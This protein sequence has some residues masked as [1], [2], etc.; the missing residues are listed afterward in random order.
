MDKLLLDNVNKII[1]KDYSKNDFNI[2][3][4]LRHEND[5]VM[6][7]SKFIFELLNPVGSH[8]L[9]G[10][11]LKLFVETINSNLD[12]TIPNFEISDFDNAIVY[13]E[14]ENIDVL[15]LF[16]KT[17]YT[18][19]IENKIYAE[20]QDRQLENYYNKM[21]KYYNRDS[22]KMFI[23]YLSLDN[24]LPKKGIGELKH[25]VY[26]ISYPR[27]IDEWLERCC[28]EI[29]Q[30]QNLYE[31]V[32]QYKIL[33]C[34]LSNKECGSNELNEIMELLVKDKDVFESAIAIEQSLPIAKS[35]IMMSFFNNIETEINK[36]GY[37]TIIFDKS[38]VKNYYISKQIPKLNFLIKNFENDIDFS[39]G[40]EIY[41]NLYYY[42]SFC[43]KEEGNYKLIPLENVEKNYSD[44]FDK[45]KKAIVTVNGDIK[46]NTPIALM[47]EYI[48]D[49]GGKIYNF[50]RFSENCIDLI[51]N[52]ENEIT[53]VVEGLLPQIRQILNII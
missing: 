46:K 30:M 43:R 6:L 37:K 48:Y 36:A 18:F 19:I 52:E 23:L 27:E 39:F 17:G 4:I 24:H 25:P 47:W 53:N 20:D 44:I 15:I 13:R 21:T 22:E 35:Q 16:S 12:V 38:A 33:I 29:K 50:K 26:C 9:K 11:F 41:D 40:I 28:K 2:F 51:E 8:N 42:Y 1:K 10:L 7:H 34:K 31:V 14:K 5:E 32:R 49:R 3:T 45:C